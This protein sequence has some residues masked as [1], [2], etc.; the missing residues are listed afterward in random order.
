VER[1]LVLL[2]PSVDEPSLASRGVLAPQNGIKIPLR[3][4]CGTPV[5]VGWGMRAIEP[6]RWDDIVLAALM[7]VIGV[8]RV[9]LAVLYDRPLGVEGTLSIA[10]VGLA[11]FILIRRWRS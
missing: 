5:A 7:L 8:P 10:C 1:E 6:A 11:L 4:P 9:V 2:L 3:R